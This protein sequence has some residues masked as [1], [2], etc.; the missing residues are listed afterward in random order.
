MSQPERAG[1]SEPQLS[2]LGLRR[3]FGFVAMALPIVLVVGNFLLDGGGIQGTISGYY[4]T[5]MRDYFVGSSCATAAFLVCYRYGRSD[6]YLS[7]AAAAFSVGLALFPTSQT[8]GQ[9]SSQTTGQGIAAL[10]H[11]ICATLF[12]LCMAY[13]SLF[14]FT[15]TDPQHTL[16]PQRRR[17]NVLHRGCGVVVVVCLVLVAVANQVLSQSLRDEIHPAFWLESIAVWAYAVSWVMAGQE[18]VPVPRG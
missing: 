7:N 9:A 15:R 5:V 13:F 17:R 4:Y 3:G 18:R 6:D 1:R 14:L 10:I 8:T 16:T 12:F 11:L 2:Y